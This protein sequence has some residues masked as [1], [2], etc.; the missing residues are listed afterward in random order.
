MGQ[1]VVLGEGD[2]DKAFLERL[3]Q[4]RQITG[5]TFGY[6]GGNGGFKDQL[7]A[8][9]AAPGFAQCQSILLMSD[10]DESATDSFKLIND[11]MKE[12][13]FPVPP[14]PLEMAIK[15][16]RP[17]LAVLMQPHPIQGADSRGCLETLLIPAMDAANPNQAN[18]V[19]RMLNCAGVSAWQKKGSQHKAKVRSLISAVYEA[20]PMHG[21]QY[22]FDPQKGLIALT[23]PIFNETA[24]V[25]QHF[26]AWSA[27]GIRPWADFRQDRGI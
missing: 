9:I 24:L 1:Y 5:L 16:G 10:N 19:D 20:D 22:C 26:A 17:S 3:C 6:V 23:D 12:C 14:R 11:Q 18:C 21:L 13:G 8:M 2:R 15:Q 27:S 7:T 4:Q 25:L